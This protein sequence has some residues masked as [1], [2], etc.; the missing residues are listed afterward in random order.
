M[1]RNKTLLYTVHTAHVWKLGYSS[2]V[3]SGKFG[4]GGHVID[5]I[6]RVWWQGFY[7]YDWFC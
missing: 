1:H 7:W 2:G 3:K 4:S 5:I 6:G